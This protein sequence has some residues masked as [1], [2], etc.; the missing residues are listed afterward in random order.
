MDSSQVDKIVLLRMPVAKPKYDVL[1]DAFSDSTVKKMASE[2]M[3]EL[4]ARR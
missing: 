2:N 4:L 1:F 3:F